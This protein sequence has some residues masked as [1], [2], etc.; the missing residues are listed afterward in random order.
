MEQQVLLMSVAQMEF[1]PAMGEIFEI[2]GVEFTVVQIKHRFDTTTMQQ[3]LDYF[4]MRTEMLY[5][6]EFEEEYYNDR[7]L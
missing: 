6:L 2:N 5:E 4:M 3:H 1:P 7:G